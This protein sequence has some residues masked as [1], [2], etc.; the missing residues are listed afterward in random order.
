ME[1]ADTKTANLREHHAFDYD[2]TKAVE[3]EMMNKQFT[4]G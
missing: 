3:N 1:N 2:K 4:A